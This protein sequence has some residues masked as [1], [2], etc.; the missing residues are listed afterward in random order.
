MSTTESTDDTEM[1]EMFKYMYSRLP[2]PPKSIRIE[3]L[4]EGFDE[5]SVDSNVIKTEFY[6]DAALYGIKYL[7]NTKDYNSL[8]QAQFELLNRYIKSIGAELKV[9]C[10]NDDSDPFEC[11]LKGKKVEFITIQPILL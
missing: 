8:T 6:L 2:Q 1:N 9:T 10:N 7:F 11:A 5:K 3:L 4:P